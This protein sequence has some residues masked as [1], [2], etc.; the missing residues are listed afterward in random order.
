MEALPPRT[1]EHEL[2]ERGGIPPREV[3]QIATSLL[4]GL[5]AAHQAG[6]LHRDVKP[7]NVMFR[8]TPRGRRAVLGDFGIAH[9]DGDATLT[10]TGQMMGSPAY[11]APER[12]RGERATAASDL[13]SLGVTLW[14]AVEGWSPFQRVNSLASL[15][16]VITEEPPQ[17]RHAGPLGPLLDG[18]LRKDSAHRIDAATARRLLVEAF[19]P[20]P[21]ARPAVSARPVVPATRPMPVPVPV[22]DPPAQAAPAHADPTQGDPA[23]VAL[24]RPPAPHDRARNVGPEAGPDGE[25]QPWWTPARTPAPVPGGGGTP[26]RRGRRMLPVVVGLVTLGL[27]G[28]GAATLMSPDDAARDG[29]GAQATAPSGT[30]DADA[31]QPSGGVQGAEP[32]A[33]APDDS[34]ADRAASGG[35][36]AA[37]PD[38]QEAGRDATGADDGQ[39]TEE[40]AAAAAAGSAGAAGPAPVPD[41]FQLHTDPTGFSVAVPVGW[42]VER[43]G[44]RVYLHDPESTAYLLVDQTD[45]PAADPVADWQQ[46]EPV[47]ARRL[48]GYTR[49]G[50]IEAVE[51]RGWRAADWEFVFG[52]GQRTHVLNR[53]LVTSPQRAY[54]LYWSAPSSRWDAMLPLHEQVVATFQ[55]AP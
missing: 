49:I 8:D 9:V 54:A 1:L 4:A 53:N 52:P 24:D 44:P 29:A 40:A 23:R 34:T 42:Q 14:A 50:E 32:D 5:S 2:T 12:A 31:S 36:Q 6:I 21:P 13:W 28:V 27:V 25:E 37:P 39:P 18:L 41:G 11:I 7:S 15:T 33:D 45:D 22:K 30:P 46:Q 51:F 3:A 19:P 17:A 10:A 38:G 35:S 55:P 43:E 47:V 26:R 16:A 48:E 20:Q